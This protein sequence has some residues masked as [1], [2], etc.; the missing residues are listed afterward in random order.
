MPDILSPL[1]GTFYHAPDPKAEAFKKPGD[2]V[3]AEDTIGLVE[4]MK[5]FI[6]VKAEVE[7]TF[8]GY[9]AGNAEP[10]QAGDTLAKVR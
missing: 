4:V 6:E 1:P 10:V 2:A 7:G 3:A 9:V 8:D 5:T